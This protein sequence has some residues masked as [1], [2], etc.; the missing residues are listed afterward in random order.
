MWSYRQLQNQITIYY[1]FTCQNLPTAKGL[2]V[3]LVFS[4]NCLK[5]DPNAYLGHLDLFKSACG[6]NS[7][8]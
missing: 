2:E 7:N 3:A 4:S 1:I 5:R 8:C 6:A